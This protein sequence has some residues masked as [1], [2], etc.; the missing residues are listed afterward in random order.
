MDSYLKFISN[1]QHSIVKKTKNLIRKQAKTY[2]TEKGIWMANRKLG[3]KT[4]RLAPS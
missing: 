2:F 4:L 1:S 3:Q